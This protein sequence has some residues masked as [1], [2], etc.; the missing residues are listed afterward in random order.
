MHPPQPHHHGGVGPLHLPRAPPHIQPH[1]NTHSRHSPIQPNHH[2]SSP[3]STLSSILSPSPSLSPSR[4]PSS[5]S[6]SLRRLSRRRSLPLARSL[7]SSSDADVGL[8]GLGSTLLRWVPLPIRHPSASN[9]SAGYHGPE[10]DARCNDGSRTGFYASWSLEGGGG[11][12]GAEWSDAAEQA[13][14]ADESSSA[15]PALFSLRPN[16]APPT[17]RR[18]SRKW[19]IYL[20]GGGGCVDDYSCSERVNQLVDDEQFGL[21]TSSFRKVGHT[22]WGANLLQRNQTNNPITWDWNFIYVPYCSSDFWIGDTS[23]ATVSM[24]S[25][26]VSSADGAGEVI[27]GS[28]PVL[29]QGAR[30]FNQLTDTLVNGSWN[31][32]WE[33]GTHGAATSVP[34]LSDAEEIIIAGSSAGAMGAINHAPYLSRSMRAL[35]AR[36]GV[37]LTDQVQVRLIIDSGWFINFRNGLGR[38]SHVAER[39]WNVS[40]TRLNPDVGHEGEW[41]STCADPKHAVRDIGSSTSFNVSAMDADT[42]DDA[43]SVLCCFMS[44]CLATTFI[45]DTVSTLVVQSMFDSFL[46]ALGHSGLFG[47]LVP[48]FLPSDIEG[49]GDLTSDQGISSDA[50]G[51]MVDLLTIVASYGGAY[52]T[53]F[54]FQPRGASAITPHTSLHFAIFSCFNHVYMPHMVTD[55]VEGEEP[56][57][58]RV[59]DGTWDSVVAWRYTEEDGV[60]EEILAEQTPDQLVTLKELIA[61]W[62]NY[63]AF[64]RTATGI[65]TNNDTSS[66]IPNQPALHFVD[67]CTDPQCNPTCPDFVQLDT[68]AS[69]LLTQENLFHTPDTWR[70]VILLASLVW[71]FLPAV[72]QIGLWLF[73]LASG[74]VQ[75]TPPRPGS[76]PPHLAA[77]AGGKAMLNRR[78]SMRLHKRQGSIQSSLPFSGNR[79]QTPTA[80]MHANH[81]NRPFSAADHTAALRNMDIEFSFLHLHYWPAPIKGPTIVEAAKA[82]NAHASTSDDPPP[83]R[84]LSTH[85]RKKSFMP[86]QAPISPRSVLSSDNDTQN[87]HMVANSEGDESRW[88]GAGAPGGTKLPPPPSKARIAD[89]ST[90]HPTPG[91]PNGTA[92]FVTPQSAAGGD[93]EMVARSNAVSRLADVTRVQS[94][95][96][97]SQTTEDKHD[98]GGS[99]SG[100]IDQ[101]SPEEQDGVASLSVKRND[102]SRQQHRRLPTKSGREAH[103]HLPP[104]AL[105][106]FQGTDAQDAIAIQPPSVSPVALQTPRPTH[107]KS[108]AGCT[109]SPLNRPPL[110]SPSPDTANSIAPPSPLSPKPK[111][112]LIDTD[113]DADAAGQIQLLS[114]GTSLPRASPTNNS[115]HTSY[116]Q[117]SPK[118]NTTD[119][120][121]TAGGPPPPPPRQPQH[122]F[123]DARSEQDLLAASGLTVSTLHAL[124]VPLLK[125]VNGVF[126]SGQMIA[127]MGRSG[128]GKCW[129]AGTKMLMH[130]GRVK[131][132]EDIVR[133]SMTGEVQI[134]MG[135][136]STPRIVQHGSEIIGHTAYDAALYQ[137]PPRNRLVEIPATYRISIMD[138]S[139]DRQSWSCNA[140]HI[141]VVRWNQRP[142][143]VVHRHSDLPHSPHP[144]PWSYSLLIVQDDTVVETSFYF[145]T[146]DEAEHA[147]RVADERWTPLEW[148]CSVHQFLRLSPKLRSTAMMFQPT[149]P[150]QFAPPIKSLRSRVAE[151]HAVPAE[152]ID[153]ELVESTAW[154]IGMWLSAGDFINDEA[155]IRIPHS[156]W[157]KS[158]TQDLNKWLVNFE[159]CPL[160]VDDGVARLGST[161]CALLES[162]ELLPQKQRELPL[163]L[164]RES[165][166]VRMHLLAGIIDADAESSYDHKMSMYELLAVGNGREYSDSVVSLARS[167]TFRV[168]TVGMEESGHENS[169]VN[170]PQ[171][172]A[173]GYR[174]K[175]AG[176]QLHTI[177][178]HLPCKQADERTVS[179]TDLGSCYCFKIEEVDHANYYGFTLD[180]NGR[181]LLSDYIITH[182]TTLMELLACRR[183]FG[184][185]AGDIFVNGQPLSSCFE[186]LKSSVGYVSQFG[187]SALPELTVEEN[188]LYA[189]RLRLPLSWSARR[190]KRRLE[191]VIE[192][193]GLTPFRHTVVGSND[194]SS[195]TKGGLSGG[196]RR[197]CLSS[198]TLLL[199][200]SGETIVAR[201]VKAG[202]DLLGQDMKPVKVVNAALGYDNIMYKIEYK[203][204][205]ITSS[206]I[207][208]HDH[209]VTLRCDQGP[210]VE[211]GPFAT[212]HLKWLDRHT[213]TKGFEQVTF[214]FNEECDGSE[215]QACQYAFAWL[216]EMELAGHCSPV[217]LGEYIDVAADELKTLMEQ[218]DINTYLTLPLAP[219]SSSMPKSTIIQNVTIVDGGEF[220]AIGIDAEHKRF[221]LAD[222][223]ITHNCSLAIELISAPKLLILDELTSGLDASSAL[224]LLL[225]LHSIAESTRMCILLSIH[226]PRPEVWGLFDQVVVMDSG[227]IIFQGSPFAA[228]NEFKQA[229]QEAKALGLT[230]TDADKLLGKKKKEK[231][232][233]TKKGK[234]ADGDKDKETDKDKEP[235]KHTD[236]NDSNNGRHG[237][238]TVQNVADFVLDCLKFIPIA[239][240]MQRRYDRLYK[241]DI[242]EF[243][244]ESVDE[245]MGI[246]I[247]YEDDDDDDDDAVSRPST[248]RGPPIKLETTLHRP[249]IL[250]R[251]RMHCSHVCT[252]EL[253]RL[254]AFSRTPSELLKVPFFFLFVGTVFPVLFFYKTASAL[255]TATF[256]VLLTNI[257]NHLSTTPL[258]ALFYMSMELYHKEHLSGAVTAGQHCMALFLHVGTTSILASCLCWVLAFF[259]TAPDGIFDWWSVLLQLTMECMCLRAF[260]LMFSLFVFATYPRLTLDTTTLLAAL[261]VSLCFVFS[262]FMIP[263]RNFPFFLKW[264]LYINPMYWTFGATV[265]ERLSALFH[266]SLDIEMA[267]NSCSLSAAMNKGGATRW[268]CLFELPSMSPTD[269]SST[270]TT[271]I[272]NT[273]D[274]ADIDLYSHMFILLCMSLFLAFLAWL[275]LRAPW[276]SLQP[277]RAPFGELQLAAARAWHARSIERET[278]ARLATQRRKEAEIKRAQQMS[279]V[280][281]STM[282]QPSVF[283]GGERSQAGHTAG[284]PTSYLDRGAARWAAITRNRLF[285]GGAA[286][287]RAMEE[288]AD[289]FASEISDPELVRRYVQMRAKAQAAEREMEELNRLHRQ[290]AKMMAMAAAAA[291]D[292]KDQERARFQVIRSDTDTP[293]G[294]IPTG[295]APTLPPGFA[296]QSSMLVMGSTGL[297]AGESRLKGLHRAASMVR[298]G[299]GSG[300][301]G[302]DMGAAAAGGTGLRRRNLHRTA[303]TVG[304]GHFRTGSGSSLHSL[305]QQRPGEIK[306]FGVGVAAFNAPTTSEYMPP[307]PKPPTMADVV[308]KLLQRQRRMGAHTRRNSMKSALS[309]N[310]ATRNHDHEM[311]NLL[312]MPSH[313]GGYSLGPPTPRNSGGGGANHSTLL[314][315]TSDGSPSAVST[316][317][318]G[319]TETL[320]IS[321]PI[322]MGLTDSDAF[323]RPLT[324]AMP[325]VPSSITPATSDSQ[326]RKN[327]TD[328]DGDSDGDVD[329]AD[330]LVDVASHRAS[331]PSGVFVPSS[332]GAIELPSTSAHLHSP[333]RLSQPSKRSTT[334]EVFMPSDQ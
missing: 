306:H 50:I 102:S 160:V 305:L 1:S 220:M 93:V 43:N 15:G 131:N 251:I 205:A 80:S 22:M 54:Q 268:P 321:I 123:H 227:N 154:V 212:I 109:H 309:Q 14:W 332:H 183:T 244:Q 202:M 180:G 73:G 77:A 86:A 208:T 329:V 172:Q 126:R 317:S 179:D 26:R 173:S 276:K 53:T 288:G 30:I 78:G 215:S 88:T 28:T 245:A 314:P 188:L 57:F 218:P 266:R 203:I 223:V 186:W 10:D 303:S 161:F 262:G 324:V 326:T 278:R 279:M 7:L 117:S 164:L 40:R 214:H 193:C 289:H 191:E 296:R 204:G 166:K 52:N 127:I 51:L 277:L 46:L 158:I 95:V 136:D 2:S 148:E 139:E 255:D 190:K 243:I 229:I 137:P 110:P 129:T 94:S 195:S 333:N 12:T 231:T 65:P 17:G 71:L 146:K 334:S 45:P 58:N 143:P 225:V 59:H 233:L 322:Q 240:A 328:D 62:H 192:L 252:L 112:L 155:H 206:H 141:L 217:R 23:E 282:M 115:N 253:R 81:P 271:L 111:P 5:S 226:Q 163:E 151:V 213:L 39:N 108:Q 312:R 113:T 19:V 35:Q 287:Y 153:E 250:E 76:M 247:E 41:E 74:V 239:Q 261:A 4:S 99:G 60:A 128:C 216:D 209:L 246:P 295:P 6:S 285:N 293:D 98:K 72:I 194:E 147:Q 211:T 294:D 308:A 292:S 140:D 11:Y 237:N 34:L 224:E 119:H 68:S 284:D 207:V 269:G 187:A 281:R 176:E 249:N 114:R 248:A 13:G 319:N 37:S 152:C 323:T 24:P 87:H 135:D 182:N 315:A 311:S 149:N 100:S 104:I 234:T 221:V 283:Y 302:T 92:T 201:D 307:P 8:G 44:S 64:N 27:P 145:A 31:G 159:G 138:E 89:S 327:Q 142:G 275:A 325:P 162:Y 33:D 304:L 83:K 91:Q 67:W 236:S 181:C 228:R 219:L 230:K 125:G 3:S 200:P 61:L 122:A 18:W 280:E 150:T 189:A 79:L 85:R 165:T 134:L 298:P 241:S 20:E 254:H 169:Q 107:V 174:I 124:S 157:D 270:T 258:T 70:V 168:T 103:N 259:L 199:L 38:L 47:D 257:G 301:H 178:V 222:G 273:Y 198:S 272:L 130:D 263:P 171:H 299:G 297:A 242:Q 42:Q 84:K 97:A 66:L 75:P 21:L 118:S 274:L 90:F 238:G 156:H 25:F 331:Q 330:D 256:Y 300:E 32:G 291:A 29:F 16:Y 264:T 290:Q 63:T 177:P 235:L 310:S 318:H 101:S 265:K 36:A 267:T 96:E 197:R 316:L 133:D 132:V 49:M 170:Q 175:I 48:D 144:L 105:D 260:S 55:D 121:S 167:L 82:S 184:M 320:P 210:F 9:T 313:L 196:Q 185:V 116:P 69:T 106:V 120:G 56:I 286:L 232:I